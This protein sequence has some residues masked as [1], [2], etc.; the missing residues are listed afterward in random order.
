MSSRGLVVAVFAS[1]D[2]LPSHAWHRHDVRFASL[3]VTQVLRGFTACASRSVCTGCVVIRRPSGCPF[4]VVPRSPSGTSP[5]R[6][7]PAL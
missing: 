3:L 6:A 5:A 7:A 2:R 4:G 1:D